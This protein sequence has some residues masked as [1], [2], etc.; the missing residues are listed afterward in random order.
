MHSLDL[1]LC[2]TILCHSVEIFRRL[3]PGSTLKQERMPGSIM[4]DQMLLSLCG[5]G[6]LV[7]TPDQSPLSSFL[8]VV[9]FGLA[10]I[11]FSH[12]MSALSMNVGWLWMEGRDGGPSWF[13]S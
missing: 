6:L 1:V 8:I 10:S 11:A 12:T 4:V 5:N 9:V 7:S 13:G 3:V 2:A